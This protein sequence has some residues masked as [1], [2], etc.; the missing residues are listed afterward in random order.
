MAFPTLASI[1]TAY[2]FLATGQAEPL[3][4]NLRLLISETHRLLLALCTRDDVPETLLRVNTE[5]PRSPIIPIFTSQPRMLAKYC[6]A[7]GFMV[8]PIVA[9]TVPQGSERLRVCLHA[10]NTMAEV[11]G[12]VE[13]VG[14]WLDAMTKG[15]I[16]GEELNGVGQEASE[17]PTTRIAK[18]KI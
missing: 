8:R 3:L 5:R 18:A 10:G 7:K 11:H 15:N 1:D 4:I 9:P 6:Q 13:A 2:S 17:I 12:L 16:D 14:A